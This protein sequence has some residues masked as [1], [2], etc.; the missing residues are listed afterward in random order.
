VGKSRNITEYSLDSDEGTTYFITEI[1]PEGTENSDNKLFKKVKWT[2]KLGLSSVDQFLKTVI[3][4]V[5]KKRVYFLTNKKSSVL[6]GFYPKLTKRERELLSG[7]AEK[8]N[9]K[10]EGVDIE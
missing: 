8:I 3:P 10:H 1:H 2:H 7:L 5:P 4:Q 9:Q 6:V